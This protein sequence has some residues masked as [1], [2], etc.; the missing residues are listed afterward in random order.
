MPFVSVKVSAV[1]S[2][3]DKVWLDAERITPT[4]FFRQALE[5]FRKG[6]WHYEHRRRGRW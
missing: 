6:K 4:S 1:I 3:E 2:R 5:S